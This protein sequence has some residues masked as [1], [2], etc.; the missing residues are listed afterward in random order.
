MMHH[1]NVHKECDPDIPSF[2]SATFMEHLVPFIIADDQVGIVFIHMYFLTHVYSQS[3]LSNVLSSE[4]YAWSSVRVSL[5]PTSL[6][7]I[8]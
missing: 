3:V 5:M 1:K 2:S 8:R 7:R 4:G 6:V